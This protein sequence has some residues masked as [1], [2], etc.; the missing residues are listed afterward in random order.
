M[1][2]CIKLDYIFEISSYEDTCSDEKGY[3]LI[4]NGDLSYKSVSKFSSFDF[5][6]STNETG[7]DMQC[8]F[9]D[10]Q[11]IKCYIKLNNESLSIKTLQNTE[12]YKSHTLTTLSQNETLL[13][14][15]W[16]KIILNSKILCPCQEGQY[17]SLL[18]NNKDSFTCL[19]CPNSC[20]ACTSPQSCTKCNSS[21]FGPDEGECLTCLQYLNNENCKTCDKVN[22]L[23]ECKSCYEGS[24]LTST[25][26]KKEK[27]EKKENSFI[28]IRFDNP[29]ININII[30]FKLRFYSVTYI[31]NY[32]FQLSVNLFFSIGRNYRYLEGKTENIKTKCSQI[33]DP[34][35]TKTG[36]FITTASCDGK[37]EKNFVISDFEISDKYIEISDT[38][39]EII[40]TNI[41]ISDETA[42]K[43]TIMP[44]ENLENDDK[45]LDTLKNGVNIYIFDAINQKDGWTEDGYY[46]FSLSS[47]T[48]YNSNETKIISL[49]TSDENVVA[50]CTIPNSDFSSINGLLKNLDS[51]KNTTLSL[52]N[53][54]FIENG[55][56]IFAPQSKTILVISNEKISKKKLSKG[57]KIGIIVGVCVLV[58]ISVTLLILFKTGVCFNSQGGS[59]QGYSIAPDKSRNIMP[60]EIKDNSN[61]IRIKNENDRYRK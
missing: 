53:G 60:G 21:S 4:I 44:K 15:N 45:V 38:N 56:A 36:E 46:S 19:K 50:E 26:C 35:Q 13:I 18:S 57:A 40:D 12:K 5:N 31:L 32:K 9:K 51:K 43:A 52:K 42:K 48:K 3:T 59:K 30:S 34:I 8:T 49:Q 37:T 27:D 7:K 54:N 20:S 10:P 22:D 61:I 2:E 33:G 58:A 6:I 39:T 29:S 23:A 24:T 41:E 25:G 16:E 14:H 55:V 1:T 11:Q 28:L 47:E 17:L